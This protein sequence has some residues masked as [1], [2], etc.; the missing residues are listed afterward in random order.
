M[1]PAGHGCGAASSVQRLELC[2]LAAVQPLEDLGVSSGCQVLS[3]ISP[4]LLQSLIP[5]LK[6]PRVEITL[7]MPLWPK[8]P[9]TSRAAQ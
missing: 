7:E 4:H 2:I 3:R 1:P 9:G 6:L 8:P 5:Q